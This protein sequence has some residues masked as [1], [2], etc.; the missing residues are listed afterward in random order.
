[1]SLVR[2]TLSICIEEAEA[3]AW[4][5][6][7]D[8]YG[9]NRRADW[10]RIAWGPLGGF[11]INP[12]LPEYREASGRAFLGIGKG[13]T[14]RL[15]LSM[16]FITT[17]PRLPILALALLSAF[18]CSS[19]DGQAVVS[20][21][22]PSREN[23]QTSQPSPGFVLV[24]P[25]KSKDVFLVDMQGAV[26]HSWST[27]WEPGNSVYLTERGTLYRCMRI[28]DDVSFGGG[29]IGGGVQE[30]AADGSILWEYRM[31]DEERHAH[32]DIEVLPNGNLLLIAW[33]QHTREEALA[34]GRDPELLR[35]ELFWP[36]AIFE[37]Q[38]LPDNEG[39]VVWEW[40]SWDHLIQDFDADG[41]N[42]GVV[43]DHPER[44]DINGDRDPEVVSPEEQD[45]EMDRLADLGYAGGGEHDAVADVPKDLPNSPD[46]ESVAEDLKEPTSEDLWRKKSR[47]ADWMHTNSI[48]YHPGLDQIVI[49]VRRFDEV[50]IIDHSTTSAEAATGQGGRAGRGGDLLY[51]WG[52]PGAYGMGGFEDRTLIGQHDVQWIDEGHLGAGGL[53]AFNNGNGRP[54]GDWS[55]VEE[56]WPPLTSA[57][58][59][60]R[61]PGERFGPVG[62][63]WTYSAQEPEDFYSSFI[64]GVQRL[65][66]GNTLICSGA[67][68]LVFEVNQAGETLWEWNCNLVPEKEEE[69]EEES[70]SPVQRNSLFRAT[71]IDAAHPGLMALRNMGIPIPLDP[72]GQD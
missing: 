22:A 60:A 15:P 46:G 61:E 55:S 31:A 25:L 49:S 37:V 66:N 68:G 71:R 4:F 10:C 45:A 30:I 47:D 40:H 39:R 8:R 7:E 42:F 58:T 1:M 17:M 32:H 48:D 11:S 29:G 44:I 72:M 70:K 14:S 23:G 64:S 20:I 43:S 2:R 38:P 28:E 21:E 67:P 24:T 13:H 36:D 19:G 16:S 6:R 50:W 59:Y 56:W 65:P 51:R 3:C 12:R 54:E 9:R 26:M 41:A 52:N 34:R 69:E 53:I 5:W 63:S 33:E 27:D 62:T 18:G 57:G 35:G